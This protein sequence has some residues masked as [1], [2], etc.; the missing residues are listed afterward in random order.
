MRAIFTVSYVVDYVTRKVNDRRCSVT[1][2]VCG[3]ATLVPT[4]GLLVTYIGFRNGFNRIDRYVNSNLF[5]DV[6]MQKGVW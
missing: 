6:N 3:L 1:G 2:S 5:P 4:K